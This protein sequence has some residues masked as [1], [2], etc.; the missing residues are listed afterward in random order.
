MVLTI[1]PERLAV[2]RL[3][4]QAEIPT[5]AT[6]RPFFSVTRTQDELSV[7]CREEDVPA[8][9]QQEKGWRALKVEGPFGFAVVGVLATLA[10]PL[11][12][13]GISILAFCTYD[14]DYVLVKESQLLRAVAV[15][16]ERGHT[17]DE[18]QFTGGGA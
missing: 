2:C 6:R 15:L 17:F 8:G 18:I 14:T 13:A 10:Q 5:W 3:D 7:I 11:A 12:A 1:L 9:V 4:A 16:Q